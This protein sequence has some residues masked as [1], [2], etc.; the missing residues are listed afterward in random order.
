MGLG[1]SLYG[2]S[3]LDAQAWELWLRG[4]RG[5]VVVLGDAMR[6]EV[7][8]L[9]YRLDEARVSRLGVET[10]VKAHDAVDL[11]DPG[12]DLLTGDALFKYAE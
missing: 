5:V 10:V 1:V 7:Y 8:L 11:I 3:T 9:R 4:E 6:K 2:L 12:D